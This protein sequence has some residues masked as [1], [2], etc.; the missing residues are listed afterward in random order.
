MKRY[1]DEKDPLLEAQE[2]WDKSKEALWKSTF[3]KA[4]EFSLDIGEHAKTADNAVELWAARFPR[5]LERP[6]AS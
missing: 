1:P 2:D 5:P 3:Y 4:L 6:N